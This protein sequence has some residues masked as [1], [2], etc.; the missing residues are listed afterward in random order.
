MEEWMIQG[1][2]SIIEQRI[3]G[4]RI[5]WK[6]GWCR[7][8]YPLLTRRIQGMRIRQNYV[9]CTVYSTVYSIQ[10]SVQYTVQNY[11]Q[12]TVYSTELC[13]VY[14]IQYR[15]MYTSIQYLQIPFLQFES[16]CHIQLSAE[17]KHLIEFTANFIQ[18]SL[19]NILFLYWLNIIQQSKSTHCNIVKK[20]I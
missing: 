19:N 6:N 8:Q 2:V 16:S 15:T 9:Q 17:T 10:Y 11:V 3:Q 1:V 5:Q 18:C 14:S 12:C 7:V 13:T 20:S 4:G